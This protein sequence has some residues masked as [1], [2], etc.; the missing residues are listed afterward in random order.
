MAGTLLTR[1]LAALTGY[2][3]TTIHHWRRAGQTPP[4]TWVGNRWEYD[5]DE[6]IEWL[7]TFT[8]H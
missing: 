3:E 7:S 4:A 6:T 1:H 2:T 5:A 8:E